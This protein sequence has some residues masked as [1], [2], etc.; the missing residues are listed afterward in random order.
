MSFASSIYAGNNDRYNGLP[1][2]SEIKRFIQKDSEVCKFEGLS[3]PLFRLDPSQAVTTYHESPFTDSKLHAEL[4]ERSSTESLKGVVYYIQ[5]LLEVDTDKVIGFYVRW[6]VKYSRIGVPNKT[7]LDTGFH[8]T[9]RITDPDATIEDLTVSLVTVLE[10]HSKEFFRVY[11]TRISTIRMPIEHAAELKTSYL[12][13]SKCPVLR[14]C[15]DNIMYRSDDN[16]NPQLYICVPKDDKS[17]KTYLP[18][19][20]VFTKTRNCPVFLFTSLLENGEIRFYVDHK[21]INNKKEGYWKMYQHQV[22]IK[23]GRPVSY[24]IRDSAG[25]IVDVSDT[26]QITQ[27]CATVNIYKGNYITH[28][29]FTDR[30]L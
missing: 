4:A 6:G 18:K 14:F 17:G 13:F 25:H 28:K 29:Y 20:H 10:E 24:H 22:K 27:D 2:E 3:K 15:N 1:L 8:D 11:A 19:C 9:L 5:D 26:I 30:E 23:D 12:A 16:E 21:L 7:I